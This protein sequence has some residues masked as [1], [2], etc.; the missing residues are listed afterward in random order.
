MDLWV[1]L[2]GIMQIYCASLTIPKALGGIYVHI[3]RL[4]A[5]SLKVN[6][7][8]VYLVATLIRFNV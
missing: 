3:L 7:A 4:Q 5:L 6:T 2:I 1:I 8:I